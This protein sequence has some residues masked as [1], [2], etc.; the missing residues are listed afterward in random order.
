MVYVIGMESADVYW[1]VDCE[2]SVWIW[3][4]GLWM[5][6]LMYGSSW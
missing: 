6:V 2:S 5:L 1:R 3:G 4:L